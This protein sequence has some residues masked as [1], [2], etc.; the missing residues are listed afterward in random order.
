MSDVCTMQHNSRDR[1]SLPHSVTVESYVKAFQFKVLN[2][3]FYTNSKLHWIGYIKDNLRSFCKREPQAIQHLFLW[4][5][6][7][8]FFLE[9]FRIKLFFF[10]KQDDTSSSKIFN[11]CF[12]VK[13][14]LTQLLITYRKH[15]FMGVEKT[16][17][18]RI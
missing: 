17:N 11:W 3:I 2:L 18:I 6:S 8:N 5:L 15:L 10:D 16:K 7:F 12:N 13:M 9:R 14:S 4:L 1:I